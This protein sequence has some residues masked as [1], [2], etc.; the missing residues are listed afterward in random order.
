MQKNNA[1]KSNHSKKRLWLIPVIAIA[2]I[3]TIL[4]FSY[5]GIIAVQHYEFDKLD[6]SLIGETL[7]PDKVE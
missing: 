5:L 4:G 2:S 3:I 6:Q 7:A 1:Q